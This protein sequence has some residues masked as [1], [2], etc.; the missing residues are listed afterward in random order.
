MHQNASTLGFL[1]T[2][3][4]TPFDIMPSSFVGSCANCLED[5]KK[6]LRL[7]PHDQPTTV[8]CF[9]CHAKLTVKLGEYRFVNVGQG[10]AKLQ[11][12]QDQVAKL[13][14]KKKTKKRKEDALVV[15]QPLPDNGTCSHYRKSKRWFRFPCCH[16]LYPCDVCHDSQEDHTYEYAKRHVCGL[17]SREQEIKP[18]CVGCGHEFERSHKKGAFWEGGQGVRDRVTMSRKVRAPIIER[19]QRRD[20]AKDI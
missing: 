19:Q 15:G 20:E 5:M 2:A 17:C 12:S 16:K 3:G 18:V 1:Q 8:S 7:S 11:A 10:G 6:P 4:C 14:L 13:E 9:S